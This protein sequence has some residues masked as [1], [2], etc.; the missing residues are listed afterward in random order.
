MQ[1]MVPLH[2][3]LGVP[4][5]ADLFTFL[6][7]EEIPGDE[8][9]ISWNFAKFLVNREGVCVSRYKPACNPLKIEGDIECLLDGG[10]GSKL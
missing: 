9:P 3:K 4:D 6:Q 7:E 2:V 5:C 10:E 8:G 1:L